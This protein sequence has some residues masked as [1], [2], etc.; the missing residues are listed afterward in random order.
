M[1]ETTESEA[2]WRKRA[3]EVSTTV[4][5]TYRH[6]PVIATTFGCLL[7]HFQAE[8]GQIGAGCPIG[9]LNAGWMVAS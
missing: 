3:R 6:E 9:L 8:G 2:M 4:T 1:G 5:F 7:S